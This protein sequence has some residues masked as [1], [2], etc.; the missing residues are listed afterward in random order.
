MSIAPRRRRC[1]LH[2]QRPAAPGGLCFQPLAHHDQVRHGPARDSRQRE[3]CAL[4]RLRHGQFQAV[5][6]CLRR[7]DFRPGGSALYAPQVGIINPSE[8]SPEKSLEAVVWV[9]VGGR[10]TLIGPIIGSVGVNALKSWATRAFPDCGSYIL[11]GLFVLIVLFMPKGIVGIPGQLRN[12]GSVFEKAGVR[13]GCARWRS[14]DDSRRN[15]D[16]I[17]SSPPRAS[18]RAST[19]SRRSTISISTWMRAN[20]GRSSARTARA[21]AP[22]SI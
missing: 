10:G 16:R 20:C 9:A 18:T 15:E 5:R 6:L 3:P 1:L 17:L 12:C 2:A 11:G 4:F 13:A 19:A 8:M 21:R 22:F 7:G 14:C